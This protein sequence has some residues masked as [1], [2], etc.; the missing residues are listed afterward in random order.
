MKVAASKEDL[1]RLQE[2]IRHLA[3]EIGGRGS[4]TGKEQRAAEYAAEQM[5]AIGL[6]MV[7]LEA[8]PGMPSTYRPY[9]LAFGVALLGILLS[10]VGDGREWMALA[11]SLNGLG[12]WGMLMETDFAPNWTRRLVPKRP[13]HNAVGVIPAAIQPR[14]RL[15]ISAHL[16]S[17]RTPVFY[18]S[19]SWRRSFGLLVSLAFLSMAAGGAFLALGALLG[20]TWVRWLS[21]PAAAV[22]VAA[23]ALCLQADRTPFS[24]GANDNASG[25]GVVLELGRRLVREPLPLTEVWLVFTGCEETDASGMAAFLDAHARNL[26]DEAIY[27]VLDE[28]GLGRLQYLTADGLVIKRSTH[29]RALELARRATAALPEL[30]VSPQV[31]IAYTDATVVTKRKLVALSIGCLP[32]AQAGQVSHWHQMSDTPEHIDPR[33][34]GDSIAFAWQVVRE[35][36]KI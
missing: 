18:S 12:A 26:G 33:S 15:V 7:R 19:P 28:P 16:D 32:E 22:Q 3:V 35:V 21:L 8:F 13:S 4:C 10:W 17:H 34:L 31:G 23:L 5:K 20:A 30:S 2:H 14:R 6:Q 36:D 1:Q 9:A 11:A 27:L 29:P 24:P 25:V